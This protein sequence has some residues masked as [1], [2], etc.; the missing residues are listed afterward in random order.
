[1]SWF[2]NL[3]IGTKLLL[4]FASVAVI[5]GFVGYE[6]ITSLKAADD[7]DT[8]LYEENIP[9][10]RESADLSTAFHRLRANVVEL[11]HATTS[12]T[13]ADLR[14]KIADR[15]KEIQISVD[16]LQ[17]M[18]TSDD[19]KKALAELAEARS[20]FI[21]PLD[22]TIELAAAGKTVDALAVW[23]GPADKARVREQDAI[24]ALNLL[25]VNR[26]KARS[27]A[28]TVEA[29]AATRNMLI[30]VAI[31]VVISLALGLF[32]ARIIRAPLTKLTAA[33]QKLAAGN[34]NVE[35]DRKVTKDELG[36][37]SEAFRA[38]VENTRT[39]AEVAARISSGDLSVE[40]R[41]KSEADALNLA[42]KQA[43]EALRGLVNEAGILTKAAVE[44]RL[45]TRGNAEKFEGGFRD[46]VQGVNNTLD[47]VIG[48]LNVAATYMDRISRGDIPAR[49]TDTYQGDF[50]EIKNNLNRAIDAVNALVA[51][52]HL[53]S[54]S[55]VEGKLSTRADASKH[56]G[57]FRKIV[58]GVN[59]TLDS[60]IKPVQESAVVLKDMGTGDLTV[61]MDGNYNGDLQLLKNSINQVAE[62]LEKALQNVT[63]AVTATAS[64]SNEISSSTEQMAAGAEEQTS[65]AAEVASSVEEM[66][67][68][69]MEN[70]QNAGSAAETA[71]QARMSAEQGGRVVDETIAGMKRIAEVVNK[72]ADT[73]KELGKSSDQ[74]GEIISVIDDIADQTNLLALNAAIEAARAGEQGRGFA[75]VADEV[76]KLAERTT[77]ATKEIAGMIKKIQT[78]TGGAVDSMQQGTKEVQVGIQLA[79]KAGKS[80][81]EIVGIS[82][83][84]TDMVTQIAAASEQQSSASE[85]IAKNVEAISKVTSETAQGTQQIARAA[86]DLNQLTENL[87]R[88]VAA[89]KIGEEHQVGVAATR[90]HRKV[91]TAKVHVRKDGKLMD[92]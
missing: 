28:N 47:A 18:V 83:K 52:A 31:G 55:A 23:D 15:R 86:E 22:K 4:G 80:L 26:A 44:G 17:R 20:E 46:I 63:E 48:P 89:F 90:T 45:A 58:Q 34:V 78:D 72:S 39:Q 36:L 43:V 74:I 53:L 57:D 25:L 3:K 56:Q 66:T 29:N 9:P 69:I 16:S 64:A 33:S 65:Q 71:K 51:D 32:L 40:V 41:P 54:T 49:I 8:A 24:A 21:P 10:L 84:V 92:H 12:E 67:K 38:M 76:R 88:Q 1:M 60:V 19:V 37:L 62:S 87:Q 13:K 73:V 75:V 79:D 81:Q 42:L 85:Q 61:R 77:K 59:D 7:S 35:L 50:S 91:L 6:G 27:D 11:V 68:T 5:A 2:M 70:S 30:I 14:T 82:Q